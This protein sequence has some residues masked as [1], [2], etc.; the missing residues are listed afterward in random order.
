MTD[1]RHQYPINQG[2]LFPA[3]GT[4]KPLIR[5]RLDSSTEVLEGIYGAGT[6]EVEAPGGTSGPTT[7]YVVTFVGS[8][9]DAPVKLMNT[10]LSL[11]L[12][13]PGERLVSESAKGQPDG[14]VVAFVENIG[15]A[16]AGGRSDPITVSD[17]HT[18]T[19]GSTG[20]W[21]ARVRLTGR[22]SRGRDHRGSKQPNDAV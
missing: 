17:V 6:V 13:F 20:T 3:T 10:E 19:S 4:S 8:R 9:S 15:D 14:E 21:Q 7:H 18:R 11:D 1:R 2:K 5:P 12:G 22:G 16:N